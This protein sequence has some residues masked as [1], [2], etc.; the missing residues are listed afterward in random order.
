MLFYIYTYVW[1]CLWLH[2]MQHALHS[3]VH[4]F[5]VADESSGSDELLQ[6]ARANIC[7]RFFFFPGPQQDVQALTCCISTQHNQHDAIWNSAR[8][9]YV[10]ES[11]NVLMLNIGGCQ[12]C[13]VVCVYTCQQDNWINGNVRMSAGSH[14]G[15][16]L[17]P[18]LHILQK[19]F[20]N[21]L[22]HVKRRDNYCSTNTEDFYKEPCL[23]ATPLSLI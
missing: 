1:I 18:F 2:C 23:L 16:G 9:H 20:L 5:H 21:L 11:S 15:P 12:L 22:F 17:K 13:L 6:Q 3:T 10:T 4:M 8:V 7:D 14:F 19:Y